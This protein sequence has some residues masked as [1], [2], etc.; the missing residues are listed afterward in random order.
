MANVIDTPVMNEAALPAE[1][2]LAV[3]YPVATPVDVVDAAEAVVM[4]SLQDSMVAH[5]SEYGYDDDARW[6]QEWGQMQQGIPYVPDPSG[7]LMPDFTDLAEWNRKIAQDLN[8][9]L[10]PPPQYD[11][12]WRQVRPAG[13]VPHVDGGSTPRPGPWNGFFSEN[14]SRV[15]RMVHT[16]SL[17]DRVL[18][19]SWPFSQ[20]IQKPNG[21]R[22]IGFPWDSRDVQFWALL[23]DTGVAEERVQRR[24]P[25]CEPDQAVG[26]TGVLVPGRFAAGRTSGSG[27]LGAT[28]I[29]DRS[30]TSFGGAEPSSRT[31]TFMRSRPFSVV[32]G[33]FEQLKT[34][35][36]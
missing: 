23:Q 2:F 26:R 19:W 17:T 21:T 5:A 14:P 29:E 4:Q 16:Y 3:S 18:D 35:L 24:Q 22:V 6:V 32:W 20:L 31:H 8:P 33:A 9:H 7:G 11:L 1:A 12:R 28:G 34:V 36:R 30:F 27:P 25:P 10:N 15:R 13:G